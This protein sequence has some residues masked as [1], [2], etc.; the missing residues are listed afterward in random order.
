MRVVLKMITMN[1]DKDHNINNSLS[2]RWGKFQK[3]STN[4]I[5]N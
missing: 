4:D 1:S 3:S 5:A 2:E